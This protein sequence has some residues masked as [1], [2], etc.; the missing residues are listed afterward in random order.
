MSRRHK[1][2]P[3]HEEHENHEA[4]V[5]PYA[6]MLTLLMGLFL[7]LWSIGRTDVEKMKAVGAGFASEISIFDGGGSAGSEFNPV[8][9]DPPLTGAD[10]TG[11]G[12]GPDAQAALASAE[13]AE[14]ARAADQQQLAAVKADLEGRVQAAGLSDQVHFRIEPRGLVV[15][16]ADGLLFDSG[17]AQLAGSARSTL[18]T[19]A[20][21]LRDSGRPLVV[22]GHT[23]DQPVEGGRFETNWELSTARATAVL[24]D[25]IDR[26]GFQP[27]L[28][29]ASGFADTVPLAENS[30]ADG[31]ARNRRVEIVVPAA[32]VARPG[33]EADAVPS[34]IDPI[35]DPLAGPAPST[36]AKG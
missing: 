20:G 35:G 22:E 9:E 3:P 7:V 24:R 16:V 34:S 19:V 26:F 1:K 29:A 11:T 2:H 28:L 36:A 23:D 4:W 8:A 12:S 17:S 13:Q 33:G 6:D 15:V 25:L 30:T 18:E 14:A 31:R 5:I 21:P 27:S 32:T 10:G